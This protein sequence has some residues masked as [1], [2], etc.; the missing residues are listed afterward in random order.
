LE[1][2]ATH[3]ASP[4]RETTLAETLQAETPQTFSDFDLDPQLEGAAGFG[5]EAHFRP[6]VAGNRQQLGSLDSQPVYPCDPSTF[7]TT[8]HDCYTCHDTCCYGSRYC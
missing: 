3:W 2:S 7:A 6:E 8:Y 5:W 4:E 1:T